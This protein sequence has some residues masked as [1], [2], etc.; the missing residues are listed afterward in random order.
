[1]VFTPLFFKVSFFK[2]NHQHLSKQI[3][4]PEVVGFGELKKISNQS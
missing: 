2:E 4:P 1:M 3:K